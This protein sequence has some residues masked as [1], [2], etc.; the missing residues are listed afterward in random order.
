M[1]GDPVRDDLHPAA[2]GGKHVPDQ[3][4]PGR[5]LSSYSLRSFLY[6]QVGGVT[7]FC[8]LSLEKLSNDQTVYKSF[9]GYYCNYICFIF[10]DSIFLPQIFDLNLT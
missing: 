9:E 3:S 6:L 1:S 5:H 7:N 4:C 8:I 2:D 10:S